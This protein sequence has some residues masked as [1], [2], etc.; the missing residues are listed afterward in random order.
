MLRRETRRGIP[1]EADQAFEARHALPN[2]GPLPARR[3]LPREAG[4]RAGIS[5]AQRTH[6]HRPQQLGI[7][8]T[9]T[10]KLRLDGPTSGGLARNRTLPG[11]VA[12]R[13]LTHPGG[14]SPQRTL[15]HD[16]Y[17]LVTNRAI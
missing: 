1:A 6:R 15:G 11:E 13:A 10:V 4:A 17:Q 12:G 3:N 7:P 14:P 8:R 2:L 9:G 16:M 5:V